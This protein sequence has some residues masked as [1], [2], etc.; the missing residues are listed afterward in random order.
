MKIITA[1][2]PDGKGFELLEYLHEA[3]HITA[4]I[5]NARGSF[6]GGAMDKK[7]HPLEEQKEVLTC[8][9]NADQADEVFETLHEKAGFSKP[10]TG[11]M[12][13]ESLQFSS[14]YELPKMIS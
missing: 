14:T 12:F 8:I 11:F 10:G 5:H 13:M 2:L 7:G 6:I 1:Y 3:G 9:L 4:N